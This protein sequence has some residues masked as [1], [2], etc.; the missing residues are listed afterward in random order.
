MLD[1]S[2]WY[3]QGTGDGYL[4][5]EA[6]ACDMHGGWSNA[7][8]PAPL[9]ENKPPA[10]CALAS[11]FPYLFLEPAAM[12]RPC[13]PPAGIIDNTYSSSHPLWQ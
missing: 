10:T 3:Q 6:P 7:L 11:V 9:A 2:C 5:G 12:H 1:K 13:T 4:N 8:A